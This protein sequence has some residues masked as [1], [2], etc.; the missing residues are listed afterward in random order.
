MLQVDVGGCRV[1]IPIFI[2]KRMTP[3]GYS[4]PL[5]P[6]MAGYADPGGVNPMMPQPPGYDQSASYPS[7]AAAGY[8][9]GVDTAPTAPPKY[10]F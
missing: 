7:A 8:S 6:A 3:V 1:T 10:G 2:G 9:G 5:Y 4:D